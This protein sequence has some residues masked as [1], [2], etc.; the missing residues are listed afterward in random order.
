M[1]DDLKNKAEELAKAYLA[2]LKGKAREF[3]ETRADV[4]ALMER[5]ARNM[6]ELSLELIQTTDPDR[7]ASLL[8][9]I[10]TGGETIENEVAALAQDVK[11]EAGSA[12]TDALKMI[13]GFAKD[14]LP[15]I[16]SLV[17]KRDV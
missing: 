4:K 9:S 3:Y 17:L 1:T 8:E 14:A 6:A 7:R 15:T 16:I 13:V 12:I 2:T 5:T 10:E 11:N